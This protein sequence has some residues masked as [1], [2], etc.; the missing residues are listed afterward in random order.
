MA[1]LVGNGA[2]DGL[3]N[4][5]KETRLGDFFNFDAG[6]SLWLLSTW[7]LGQRRHPIVG[8]ILRAP[9][10]SYIHDTLVSVPNQRSVDSGIN[11]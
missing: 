11:F 6:P 9:S 7:Y 1:L 10:T 5:A 4:G 8:P 2:T 3:R